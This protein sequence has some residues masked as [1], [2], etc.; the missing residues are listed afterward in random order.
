MIYSICSFQPSLGGTDRDQVRSRSRAVRDDIRSLVTRTVRY[1]SLD[2]PEGRSHLL[3]QRHDRLQDRS[4]AV[5]GWQP[6]GGETI[7][8]NEPAAEDATRTAD[9]GQSPARHC[10]LVAIV[11]D[12]HQEGTAGHSGEVDFGTS[13][14]YEVPSQSDDADDSA[15]ANHLRR[16]DMSGAAQGLHR[17]Y[18]RRSSN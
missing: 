15:I 3:G 4:G 8:R 6:D 18:S 11:P 10:C 12:S 16:H 7:R 13:C 17:F 9:D 2:L 5:V 1:W 14:H